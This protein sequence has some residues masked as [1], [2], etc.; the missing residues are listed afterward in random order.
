MDNF[1][2][3]GWYFTKKFVIAVKFGKFV[4]YEFPLIKHA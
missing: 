2:Q 4:R 1:N 3:F